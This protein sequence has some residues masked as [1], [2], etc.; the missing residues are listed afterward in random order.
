MRLFVLTTAATIALAGVALAQSASPSNQPPSATG[1]QSA[2]GGLRS[3]DP[4]TQVKLTFYTVQPADMRASKILGTEV[5]NLNNEN[6]GEVEDLV[7]DN[8]KTIKGV[9]VSVGGF[10]GIGDRNVALDPRS[11]VL[12]EQPDGSAR[13]VVNTTKDDLKNAPP[14][15]FA[16][17]DRAGARSQ[18]TGSSGSGAALRP[19]SDGS[20]GSDARKPGDATR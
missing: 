19:N 8:G 11:V 2:P 6:I 16:D 9:V 1:R 13:F 14:F 5:Y 4:G 10:L 17:V 3:V 12:T 18:T 15:N 20:T 7:I